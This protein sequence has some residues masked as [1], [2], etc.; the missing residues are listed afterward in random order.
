MALEKARFVAKKYPDMVIL[1]SDTI[2]VCGKRIIQKANNDLEQ[3]KTMKLISGKSHKVISSVCVIDKN[4]KEKLKL[5]TTKI[6]MKR[7]SENEINKYVE[8]HEW[9]GCAGYKIEGCLAAFV[10]KIIGS[11]SGVV[12]L[13]LY[14]TKNLLEYAGIR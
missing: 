12:G 6:V 11:Y 7:L 10:K 4:G 1:A 2:I 8:T 3:V 5:N 9:V 13:P 14:E